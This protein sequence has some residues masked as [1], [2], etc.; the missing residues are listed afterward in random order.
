M[1]VA[2]IIGLIL[3]YLCGLF[4]S[5]RII[6]KLYKK[7]LRKEGSGNTGM[8]NS[9]RVLG[10]SA[11][12]IV[13]FGD[14]FKTVAPMAILWAVYHGT[15]PDAVKMLELYAGIGAVLGHNFPVYAKFK[16][17][18]GIASTVGVIFSFHWTMCFICAAMFFVSVIPTGFMSLGSLAIL[19]GFFLQTVIFGQLGLL[20]VGAQ[21]LPELYVLVGFL[22]VLAFVR[23]REN[24]KR[25]A[26][27]EENKFRP[28]K[29]KK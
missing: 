6:G 8:T 28:G 22:T 1:I 2:R 10:W 24:L 17:G 18:K 14:C 16:G 5:G 4:P 19:T 13:F 26:A 15:Y 27:G 7:D 12:V 3:G 20:H 11:G 21:Y 23:H 9:I 29:G 25:L